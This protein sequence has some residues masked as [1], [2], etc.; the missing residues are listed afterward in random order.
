M[1][2]GG[3]KLA[4]QW[5]RNGQAI[6]GATINLGHGE[7]T[8]GFRHVE[9][10]LPVDAPVYVL[11]AIQEDGSIGAPDPESGNRFV[12]SHRSEEE[13]TR[14]LGKDA[15]LLGLVA[16]GLAFLGVV[17]LVVGVASAAGLIQFS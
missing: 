15:R 6:A 1:T 16:A 4:W 3:G 2:S 10:I 14:Q 7:R 8:I 5:Q 11:G 12:V 13:L 9:G 17:F